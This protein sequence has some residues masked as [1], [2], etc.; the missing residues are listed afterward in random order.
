M[1][2]LARYR[3]IVSRVIEDYVSP[4]PA[5][6]DI[7]VEL[8]ID[9]QRDHYEIV[10]VGWQEYRRV[11]GTIIHVDIIDGKIWIQ[12]DGTDRPIADELVAAGIP[13]EDIVLA[14]HPE[15]LRKHTGFAVG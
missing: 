6:G 9:P 4:K 15:Y 5:N 1:D 12:Y 8:V 10:H 2:Q 11:H 7:D 14:F 13:K 3:E